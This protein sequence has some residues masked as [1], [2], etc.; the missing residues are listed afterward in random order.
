MC[1]E[2]RNSRFWRERERE[3]ERHTCPHTMLGQKQ[4]MYERNI[5]KNQALQMP[6]QLVHAVLAIA[7][8]VSL[9]LKQRAIGITT[10][11]TEFVEGQGQLR[12][13]ALFYEA[14]ML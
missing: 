11:A 13:T 5:V 9:L 4:G 14:A 7:E 8:T 12:G 3:R 2:G 1:S 10:L 6:A